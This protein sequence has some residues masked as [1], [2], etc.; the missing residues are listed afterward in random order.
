MTTIRVVTHARTSAVSAAPVRNRRPRGPCR[1]RRLNSISASLS[2]ES[3]TGVSWNPSSGRSGTPQGR[4]RE[5]PGRQ[6]HWYGECRARPPSGRPR[7]N[8]HRRGPAWHAP[9]PCATAGDGL[10]PPAVDGRHAQHQAGAHKRSSRSPLVPV[11]QQPVTIDPKLSRGKL[12][13]SMAACSVEGRT[14]ASPPA[15]NRQ[16]PKNGRQDPNRDDDGGGDRSGRCARAV[17]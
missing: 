6:G 16:P 7:E 5:C 15:T 8:S 11:S 3:W 1:C 4:D 2:Y 12:V 9:T 14:T 10:V 13:Q 17:H